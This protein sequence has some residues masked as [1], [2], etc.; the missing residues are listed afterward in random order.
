MLGKYPACACSKLRK[1][2]PPKK[3]YMFGSRIII[4]VTLVPVSLVIINTHFSI[5]TIKFPQINPNSYTFCIYIHVI[6]YHIY[7]RGGAYPPSI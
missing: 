6:G 7:I 5:L 1:L 3:N 2:K 4:S